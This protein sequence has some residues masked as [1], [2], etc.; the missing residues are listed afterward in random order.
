MSALHSSVCTKFA[1][2]SFAMQN[3]TFGTTPVRL[4]RNIVQ[5]MQYAFPDAPIFQTLDEDT[6]STKNNKILEME[7][8]PGLKRLAS[9]KALHYIVLVFSGIIWQDCLVASD[10]SMC[11]IRDSIQTIARALDTNMAPLFVICEKY[12]NS[13][14][15]RVLIQKT[16]SERG[17]EIPDIGKLEHIIMTTRGYYAE[18]AECTPI[19]HALSMYLQKERISSLHQIC[20]QVSADVNRY[21]VDRFECIWKRE[22]QHPKR[23]WF[24]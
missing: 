19:L 15:E 14:L 12:H 23:M 5:T 17:G 6:T 3:Y 1:V 20:E 9:K 16:Q 18:S 7:V 24:C 10:G 4:K 11:G 8:I 21:G 2:V 13:K 22:M